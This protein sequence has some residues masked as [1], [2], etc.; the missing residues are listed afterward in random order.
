M[1]IV[2]VTPPSAPIHE[3]VA[4][5]EWSVAGDPVGALLWLVAAGTFLLACWLPLTSEL[6]RFPAKNGVPF[7]FVRVSADAWGRLHATHSA[8]ESPVLGNGAPHYGMWLAICALALAIA[9]LGQRWPRIVPGSRSIGGIA[10]LL[11]GGAIL[12]LSGS[13]DIPREPIE[14]D[15][16]TSWQFGWAL[17][18]MT[19]GLVFGVLALARAYLRRRSVVT[20]AV[21]KPVARWRALEAVLGSVFSATLIVAAGV[22]R[23]YEIAPADAANARV[24]HVHYL[25]DG[26]GHAVMKPGGLV[27]PVNPL[28]HFALSAAQDAALVS[29][30]CAVLLVAAVSG[31]VFPSRYYRPPED[32]G[33]HDVD[34]SHHGPAGSRSLEEGVLRDR[35]QDRLH[36]G[37]VGVDAP[38]RGCRRMDTVRVADMGAPHP[39]ARHPAARRPAARHPAARRPSARHGRSPGRLYLLS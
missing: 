8:F 38:R 5:Q 9:A 24:A 36:S 7:G 39:A 28:N 27:G 18:V 14:T 13:K 35:R 26:W 23:A 11:I 12:A 19:L 6:E 16:G 3:T 32:R 20:S 15:P 2:D 22:G 37:P 10:I 21:P 30:C 25:F 17:W 31:R 4:D 1:D 34:R 33:R 29:L